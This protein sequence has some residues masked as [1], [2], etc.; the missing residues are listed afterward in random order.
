MIFRR[1]IDDKTIEN[2][3][4][5]PRENGLLTRQNNRS[6]RKRRDENNII[7]RL[8]IILLLWFAQSESRSDLKIAGYCL[9]YIHNAKKG[10]NE[11]SQWNNGRC[12]HFS[13][14]IMMMTMIMIIVT[15]ENG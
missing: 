2:R 8:T 10:E 7:S 12:H 13:V 4:T 9:Q 15:Y 6:E 3:W 1:I 14:M 5:R 11:F